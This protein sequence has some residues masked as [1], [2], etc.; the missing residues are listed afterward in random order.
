MTGDEVIYD[1][2]ALLHAD[3]KDNKVIIL[4]LFVGRPKL[5]GAGVASRSPSMHESNGHWPSAKVA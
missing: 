4:V 5:G 1:C 3:R 2:I